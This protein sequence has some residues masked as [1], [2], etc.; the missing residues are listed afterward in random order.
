MN[1]FTAIVHRTVHDTFYLTILNET[2]E[3]IEIPAQLSGHLRM[4]YDIPIPGDLVEYIIMDGKCFI[5]KVIATHP[6]N[7]PIPNKLGVLTPIPA[8]AIPADKPSIRYVAVAE[9]PR[10]TIYSAVLPYTYP[11]KTPWHKM[12]NK[13]LEILESAFPQVSFLGSQFSIELVENPSSSTWID[14]PNEPTKNN[15]Q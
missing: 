3:Y 9:H 4:P 6:M 15:N 7:G 13:V 5:T 2:G 12:A 1:K 10:G 8:G 11:S 14:H